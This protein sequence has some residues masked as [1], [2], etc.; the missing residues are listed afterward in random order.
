MLNHRQQQIIEFQNAQIEARLNKHRKPG[1]PHIRQEIVDAIVSFA[2]GN[3][4]WGYDRVQGAL[5]NLG[6]HIADSSVANV[7]KAH[8]IEPAPGRQRTQAWSTF[9]KAHWNSI[10]ATDFTTVEV[11]TR[12]GLVTFYVLAVIH[13][14]TRR[15]QIVGITPSPN[16]TWMKQVCRNLTDSEHGFLNDASH[17]IVNRDTSFIA[18]LD[19]IEQN[20]DTEV[21]L[22]PTK[23]PNLNGYMER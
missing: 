20:T 12:S 21:V 11:W 4:T 7:L 10:F 23:S 2:T 9:L 22:L 17:L 15:V 3:P 5:K 1:R 6:Y 13:L 14:K 16:A 18:L 19:L 8:G